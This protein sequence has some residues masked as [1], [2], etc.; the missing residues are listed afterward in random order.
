MLNNKDH[1]LEII[2]ENLLAYENNQFNQNKSIIQVKYFSI[3]LLF[4]FIC[5]ILYKKIKNKK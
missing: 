3:V 5:N 1:P 2:Y 4:I